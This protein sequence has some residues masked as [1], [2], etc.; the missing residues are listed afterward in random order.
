[1][2]MIDLDALTNAARL[3]KVRLFGREMTV[4]PLTG[5]AAHQIAVIQ[6]EDT[7]GVGMIAGMIAAMARIVPDL[8]AD[9]RERLTVDQLAAL[10]QLSRGQIGDVEQQ[11][12]DAAAKN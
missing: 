11:I 3:P 7:T 1:M 2:T 10:L 5:A 4:Q 6:Q 8:T 12:A 9:E